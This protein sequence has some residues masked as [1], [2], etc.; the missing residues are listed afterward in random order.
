M[1]TDLYI[2]SHI[3]TTKKEVLEKKD[4]YLQKLKNLNL[5]PITYLRIIDNNET[6]LKFEGDWEYELPDTETKEII[7]FSSPF[8]F[9]VTVYENCLEIAT[10]YKYSFLYSEYKLH[11]DDYIWEFRKNI[12]DIISIFGGTEI[13]YLADNGCN[14][15]SSY[16]EL[17]V[18]EGVSYFDVKK[19]M[20]EKGFPFV[21][22]YHK[23]KLKDLNYSCI[24]EI[25]FDDFSD[26][27][28]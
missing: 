25:V 2:I 6:W 24:K 19:D 11:E 22:N 17:K 14:K 28:T 23:L 5:E 20:I 9:S 4:F 10:I 18:W 12:F 15:L 27:K 13:I 16:L 3:K 1:A 21:S 26:I 7:Y 8:V